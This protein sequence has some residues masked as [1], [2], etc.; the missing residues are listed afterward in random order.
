V[1][2]SDAWGTIAPGKR[3]DLVL[4]ANNPLGDVGAARRPLAVFVNGFYLTREQLDALLEERASLVSTPPEPIPLADPRADSSVVRRGVLRTSVDDRVSGFITYR[5]SRLPD[6]RWL[7]EERR[8]TTWDPG[9]E[10][11][12]QLWLGADFTVDRVEDRYVTLV[13]EARYVVEW[14]D[15]RSTYEVSFVALDGTE[16]HRSVGDRRLPPSWGLGVVALPDLLTECSQDTTVQVLAT[17]SGSGG[18]DAF[19]PVEMRVTPLE[20]DAGARA[21]LVRVDGTAAERTYRFDAD[22]HFLELRETLNG[23]SRRVVP[24]DQSTP[25]TAGA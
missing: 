14:A 12:R 6:R 23:R 13:G 19:A 16:V 15:D 25:A 5:C 21:W 1:G 11:R 4:L 7:L 2:E 20:D 18:A 8:T 9:S 3:A 22:G 10:A 24:H 17:A